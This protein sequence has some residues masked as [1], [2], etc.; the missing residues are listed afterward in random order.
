M[1]VDWKVE[2]R[3]DEMV[4]RYMSGETALQIC[5]EMELGRTS[6]NAVIGKL[7]RLGL[8]RAGTGTAKPPK[9]SAERRDAWR[10]AKQ[11]SRARLNKDKPKHVRRKPAPK[12]LP[13]KPA[14]TNGIVIECVPC[15]I[16]D[17]SWDR[18]RWP[19]GDPRSSGFYYCGAP[20]SGKYCHGHTLMSIDL[21]WKKRS[22]AAKAG[23]RRTI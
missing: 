1:V 12:V 23:G 22:D 3:I 7:H 14:V 2:G 15:D 19:M 16:H 5:D 13:P 6:M 17:L 11:E 9:M 4:S 21:V 18:C 10:R 20:A 8:T